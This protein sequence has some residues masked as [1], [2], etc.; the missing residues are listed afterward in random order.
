MAKLGLGPSDVLN[1]YKQFGSRLPDDWL[2]GNN[3]RENDLP[4][5]GNFLPW[6]SGQPLLIQNSS[7]PGL[8]TNSIMEER[9][10]HKETVTYSKPNNKQ[11]AAW[12][13]KK[14]ADSET[15]IDKTNKQ[16]HN[17]SVRNPPNDIQPPPDILDKSHSNDDTAMMESNDII[18]PQ[19]AMMESNNI[20]V[21]QPESATGE[22][23]GEFNPVSEVDVDY[24]LKFNS[25]FKEFQKDFDSANSEENS[26]III[27]GSL[28]KLSHAPL[29]S[30]E[31]RLE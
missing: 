18:V 19:P 1:L 30:F 12:K 8:S 24:L 16:F 4:T 14:L 20:I 31:S 9:D 13:R 27:T 25:I 2:E 15:F 22:M 3:R 29:L 11:S 5:F 10:T 23:I 7:F 26:C 6:Y 28:N 21:P 17:K